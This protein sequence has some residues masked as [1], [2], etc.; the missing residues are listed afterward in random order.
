MSSQ[1]QDQD[2]RCYYDL[3]SLQKLLN[4]DY[5]SSN[6]EGNV[7]WFS[8]CKILCDNNCNSVKTN[9]T[10]NKNYES[11]NKS[12]TKCWFQPKPNP[13]LCIA[14]VWWVVVV[15]H[16]SS[17]DKWWTK[18]KS[19]YQTNYP[20][21]KTYTHK[22]LYIFKTSTTDNQIQIKTGCP[23]LHSTEHGSTKTPL[24]K[25]PMFKL[26]WETLPSTPLCTLAYW[27]P[28]NICFIEIS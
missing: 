25:V 24:I 15:V 18:H 5:F 11:M 14:C 16:A 27:R 19:V 2:L 7:I 20:S 6:P 22:Y 3:I 9:T 1:G 21:S 28:I 10:T 23:K 12:G 17:Q 8:S 26:V 4:L 13:F